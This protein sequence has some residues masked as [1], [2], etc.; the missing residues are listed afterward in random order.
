MWAGEGS[1][2]C[3]YGC[4]QNILPPDMDLRDLR[5]RETRRTGVVAIGLVVW[6]GHVDKLLHTCCTSD[7][8]CASHRH[9]VGD[10]LVSQHLSR[11]CTWRVLLFDRPIFQQIWLGTFCDL[12][13]RGTTM[14]RLSGGTKRA[15]PASTSQRPSW[16]WPCSRP[17]LSQGPELHVRGGPGP[18][19]PFGSMSGWLCESSVRF[20]SPSVYPGQRAAHD[21]RAEA[22]WRV[23]RVALGTAALGDKSSAA[24]WA[25]WRG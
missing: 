5:L 4:P 21:P 16:R 17:D 22:G 7:G 20:I 11:L 10:H 13:L 25:G 3:R 19:S 12:L 23:Q 18:T 2:V 6:A 8:T 1:L 15:S 14:P 24:T 9:F